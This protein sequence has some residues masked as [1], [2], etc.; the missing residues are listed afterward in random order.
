LQDW[1]DLSQLGE[2]FPTPGVVF[3]DADSVIPDVIW[4]SHDR[5]VQLLDEAGHLTG[6]PELIVEV[7]SPGAVAQDTITSPFLLGFQCQVTGFFHP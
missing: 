3:S 5:L 4:I 2:A 1:S 6:A 7:L